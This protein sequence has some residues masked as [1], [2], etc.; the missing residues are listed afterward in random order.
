MEF[1]AVGYRYYSSGSLSGA[2]TWGGYWSSVALGSSS[3]Y[4]L[5]F[6][7]SGLYVDGGNRQTGFSV[8]CVRQ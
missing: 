8:R 4:Y 5:Y 3:A 6:D 2:G 1:P 7:S